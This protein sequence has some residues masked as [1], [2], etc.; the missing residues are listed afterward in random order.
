M[1]ST[2][3]IRIGTLPPEDQPRFT[4]WVSR[5]TRP[6]SRYRRE[7][8]PM[9]LCLGPRHLARLGKTSC[10][11]RPI[12]QLTPPT[13]VSGFLYQPRYEKNTSLCH[14]AAPLRDGIVHVGT[15]HNCR[16]TGNYVYSTGSRRVSLRSFCTSARCRRSRAATRRVPPLSARGTGQHMGAAGTNPFVRPIA[17]PGPLIRKGSSR[18]QRLRRH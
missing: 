8:R 3:Y 2:D 5:Q 15:D 14:G 17:G 12:R 16:R 11:H 13:S 9:R 6:V 7:S 1:N 18:L 4:E 10:P